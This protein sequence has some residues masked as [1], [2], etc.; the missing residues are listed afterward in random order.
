MARNKQSA[1]VSA[2]NELHA[3]IAEYMIKR[4]RSSVPPDDYEPE[5]DEETGE[6]LPAF[7]I[8]LAASE[9][10]VMVSFLNNNKI[11]ATP[12]AEHMATLAQEFSAE[13]DAARQNKARNITKITDNDAVFNSFLS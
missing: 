5:Y 12:D 2:L 1:S 9:L 3:T 10:Q 11:T 7:F 8:P 13:L 4:I 6:E